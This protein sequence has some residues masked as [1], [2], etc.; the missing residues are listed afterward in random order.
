MSE[1]SYRAP[2]PYSCI[3][4]DVPQAHHGHRA[5]GG[6]T[7]VHCWSKPTQNVI[8]QRMV[9]RRQEYCPRWIRWEDRARTEYRKWKT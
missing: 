1:Y 9:L 3:I 8:W 5:A 6:W 4:C 7:G 2:D